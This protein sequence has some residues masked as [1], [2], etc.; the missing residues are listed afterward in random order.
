MTIVPTA[1]GAVRPEKLE[2]AVARIIEGAHPWRILL[3]GSLA[4]GQAKSES[5]VD[6]LVIEEE[7]KD[8]S[9]EAARLYQSLRD[10]PLNIDLVV[11][12]REKFEYWADTPGNVY[13]EAAQDGRSLYEAA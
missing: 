8:A 3:F 1:K 5:D 10:L 13:Y 2:E 4:R 12:A 11:V 6:L 7:V 9:T